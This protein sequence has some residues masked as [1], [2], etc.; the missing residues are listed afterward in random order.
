MTFN[1]ID[2]R[3][4]E[5]VVGGFC[6]QR[7]PDDVRSQVKVFYEIRGSE[8]KIIESRP[9]MM[10]SHLWTE[11]PVAR[12]KYDPITMEWELYWM[13]GS[14]KWQKYSDLDPARDLKSLV[15]E[16]QNDPHR[17]FWW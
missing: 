10:G 4:I 7:I 1:E 2:L 14:G 11:T 17:L 13:N 6:Q 5:K 8:V 3:R 16:I 12:L 15:S 9:T